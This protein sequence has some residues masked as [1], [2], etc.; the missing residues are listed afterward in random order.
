MPEP[1]PNE[2][3]SRQPW[4]VAIV[5]VSVIASGALGFSFYARH[6]EALV[7]AARNSGDLEVARRNLTKLEAELEA[8]TLTIARLK[9]KDALRRAIQNG[10]SCNPKKDPLCGAR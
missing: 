1:A 10:P 6:Q 2:A 3:K 9:A 8:A 7:V 4:L 5:V